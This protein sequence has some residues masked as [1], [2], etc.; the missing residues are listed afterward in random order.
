MIGKKWQQ[1]QGEAWGRCE[2]EERKA[3]GAETMKT[4]PFALRRG[5]GVGCGGAFEGGQ[6]E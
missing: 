4:E 2:T 6:V 5:G 1:T 3:E